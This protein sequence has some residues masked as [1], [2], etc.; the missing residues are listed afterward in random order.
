MAISKE[1]IKDLSTSD[2]KERVIDTKINLKKTEFNNVVSPID[3]P[4][5]IRDMRRD[6]AKLKTEIRR[7]ELETSEN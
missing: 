6:I 7:R 3:N 4:L 5:L 2:L 1:D